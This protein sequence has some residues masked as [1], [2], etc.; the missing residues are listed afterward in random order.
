[1]IQGKIVE[2]DDIKKIFFN[3]TAIELETPLA[4][5]CDREIGT[6]KKAHRHTVTLLVYSR[7]AVGRAAQAALFPMCTEEHADEGDGHQG[8]HPLDDFAVQVGEATLA[9]ALELVGVRLRKAART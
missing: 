3:A 8:A 2:R 5:R 9:E 7:G 4:V 1:M 6:F